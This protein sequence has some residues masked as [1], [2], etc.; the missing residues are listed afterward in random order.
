MRSRMQSEA[1]EKVKEALVKSISPLIPQSEKGN[2]ASIMGLIEITLKSTI[3]ENTSTNKLKMNKKEA[4]RRLHNLIM[5]KTANY[6][7][8]W[9]YRSLKEKL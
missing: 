6:A 9:L 3:S 4:K 8:R 1:L 7:P 5:A 2:L